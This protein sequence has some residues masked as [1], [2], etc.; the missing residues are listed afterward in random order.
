MADADLFPVRIA[1]GVLKRT[2]KE[3]NYYEKELKKEEQQLL[4]MKDENRDEYEINKQKE[5]ICETATII[6]DCEKRF[7]SAL[8]NLEDLIEKYG[9]Q[10]AE[11]KIVIDAKA[12]LDEIKNLK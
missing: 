12:A 5:I 10:F 11:S 9:E 1:T 8:G 7:S 2:F 6:P 3:K 4:K